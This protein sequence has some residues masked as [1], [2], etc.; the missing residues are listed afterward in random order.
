MDTQRKS[1]RN[2]ANT[3]VI[4]DQFMRPGDVLI[5]QRRPK[6]QDDGYDSVR[7]ADV[8]SDGTEVTLVEFP[9]R[10]DF[11]DHGEQ[12][13]NKGCR[14]GVYQK[15]SAPIFK[16]VIDGTEHK[17]RISADI[18][19]FKDPTFDCEVRR[20]D[21]FW[22]LH[23]EGTYLRPLPKLPFMTGDYVEYNAFYTYIGLIAGKGCIERIDWQCMEQKCD[24]G[25][26]YPIVRIKCDDGGSSTFKV[27]QV[28]LIE[29]GNYWAWENDR[30]K[31]KFKDLREE[32]SFYDSLGMSEQLRSPRSGNYGW[33][34]EDALQ[35]IREGT[36]D[37]IKMG[38]GLFGSSSF[39][40]VYRF[41]DLPDLGRRLREATIKGFAEPAEEVCDDRR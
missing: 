6:S 13:L 10:E 12:W 17:G 37:V 14:T 8:P 2:K 29:R 38:G 4:L 28:K 23:D 25:S 22:K 9:L 30:S 39:P 11:V 20:D 1:S 34:K 27:S 16:W 24:D 41:P 5:V 36:A 26:L 35:A 33:T 18:L 15:M 40:T 7:Y 19:K 32:A 21:D 31:L 3:H